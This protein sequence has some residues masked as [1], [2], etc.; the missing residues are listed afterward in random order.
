MRLLIFF[1]DITG[2]S[3]I[4]SPE[5][6]EIEPRQPSEPRVQSPDDK[7]RELV[8]KLPPAPTKAGVTTE[9]VTKR[10]FSETTVKRVT[11]NENVP[12]IEDVVLVKAGGPLGLSIIGGSDHSCVPFGTGDPGIFISKVI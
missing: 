5:S 12:R 3:A 4:L 11:T 6:R 10:T 9:T 7:V 1:C 2:V 8:T